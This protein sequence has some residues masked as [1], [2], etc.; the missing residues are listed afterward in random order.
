MA[1]NIRSHRCPHPQKV[2]YRSRDAAER[3]LRRMPVI[4]GP[5]AAYECRCG[6]WHLTSQKQMP[7]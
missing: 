3:A 2:A 6:R 4:Y 1:W 7:S 5:I